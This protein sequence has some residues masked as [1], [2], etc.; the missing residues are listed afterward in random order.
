MLGVDAAGVEASTAPVPGPLG[1]EHDMFFDANGRQICATTTTWL[2]PDQARSR[3]EGEC[4]PGWVK[5]GIASSSTSRAATDVD[6]GPFEPPFR[7]A[8]RVAAMTHAYW[9]FVDRYDL[10][11]PDIAERPS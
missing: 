10:T 5:S 11:P 3:G 6:L 9:T 4:T 1:Y 8:D 7:P 2:P